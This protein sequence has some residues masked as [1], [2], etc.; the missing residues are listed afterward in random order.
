MLKKINIISME[1]LN[2]E[3]YDREIH[4]ERNEKA[5]TLP[6]FEFQND[7]SLKFDYNEFNSF[8]QKHKV[9][10]AKNISCIPSIGDS[11]GFLHDLEE[12]N[13]LPDSE[14]SE[15]KE[16]KNSPQ[17]MKSSILDGPKRHKA[18]LTYGDTIHEEYRM[19]FD[20]TNEKM[21]LALNFKK[22][23][24]LGKALKC[25]IEVLFKRLALVYIHSF[26]KI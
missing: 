24:Q 14:I 5:D 20:K 17:I 8:L 15:K 6:N 19:R 26:F 10:K 22:E 3:N 9:N 25:A 23:K 4:N 11:K 2:K 13:D 21:K 16:N 1:S 7:P 12:M 18:T